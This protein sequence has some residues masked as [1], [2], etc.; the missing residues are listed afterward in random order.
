MGGQGAECGGEKPFRRSNVQ[1]RSQGSRA[2]LAEVG[3][4]G[5]SH[6]PRRQ[7]RTGS[8]NSGVKL[9]AS[10]IGQA[11]GTTPAPKFGEAMRVPLVDFL[12]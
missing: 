1:S 3:E 7:I 9:R 12:Q 2:G 10:T 4:G 8:A 5:L 11:S 6:F